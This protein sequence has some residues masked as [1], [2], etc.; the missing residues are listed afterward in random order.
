MEATNNHYNDSLTVEVREVR[1]KKELRDF[2]YLPEKIH[3][4]H[5]NW[6]PPIYMDEWVTLFFQSLTVWYL[7]YYIY[8]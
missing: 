3:Q 7:V 8:I 5:S 6:V 2:I 1:T 4:N